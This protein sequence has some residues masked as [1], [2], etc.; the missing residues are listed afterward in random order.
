VATSASAAVLASCGTSHAALERVN[1]LATDIGSH[2][3]MLT[4]TLTG[5]IIVAVASVVGMM[6]APMPVT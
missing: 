3:I 6:R 5:V 1:D 2:E 4:A